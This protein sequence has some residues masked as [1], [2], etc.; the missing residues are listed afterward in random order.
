[1]KRIKK[2]KYKAPAYAFGMTQIGNAMG[3][4]AGVADVAGGV[5]SAFGEAGSG[6]DIAG[7][8]ISGAAKGA[9]VGMAAG[10]IGAVAGGVLGL[11]GG[12]FTGFKK[13]KQIRDL[14]RRQQNVKDVQIGLGNTAN[15]E[16]DYWNDNSLAYT[17]A[18]GGI[19][20]NDLAYLDNEEV[21]R[22]VYGNIEQIPNTT[23]GTDQHLVDATDLESVLSDKIKR[24][25]TNKTFAQEGKKLTNMTKPSK[26]KDL[27]AEQTNE[28]NR[29]NANRKYTELLTEQEEVKAQKGIKSK[30]KKIPR[31]AN[32]LD[33]TDWPTIWNTPYD[34]AFGRT[35]TTPQ[36]N[37]INNLSPAGRLPW[38]PY[39]DTQTQTEIPTVN[40]ANNISINSSNSKQGTSIPTF[41]R[42]ATPPVQVF[43][44][45]LP[46]LPK[47]QIN[48]PKSPKLL[49]G[50]AVFDQSKARDKKINYDKFADISSLMDL[51][52]SMYNFIQGI[53]GPE[54]EEDV[55]NPYS[56]V[57]GNTMARRRMNINPAREANKKSRAIANYNAANV[58]PNTGSNLAF[59][60]QAAVSEY[61][62]NADMYA[63]KQNADNAYLGEYANTMNNL[64][65]QYVQG[66]RLTNDANARNRAMSRN[67]TGTGLSQIGQWNQVRRQE[68]N[69][70]NRDEMIYPFLRNFLAYGNT[71]ELINGLD[72]K[73]YGGNK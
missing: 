30:S 19:V 12:L 7:G 54:V 2:N 22:D 59:R 69:Q 56:S 35:S 31:Y 65:Q 10:P 26:G 1:M 71:Q 9:S 17:Y 34:I 14:K 64:G 28:L 67:F 50:K 66:R 20:P 40:A 61:A 44:G 63:T 55:S 41:N 24:P 49:D 46:A 37:G 68:R 47:A 48:M 5:S 60:T 6:A 23:N 42:V 58:N 53:R 70:A 15:M 13:R 45:E 57:I 4:Y 36:Y 11:A 32:G 43:K 73:Y 52:P 72:N 3:D 38:V 27:F 33:G 18:N 8:A 21:I 29:R 51:A 62:N 25:G 16:A 39:N